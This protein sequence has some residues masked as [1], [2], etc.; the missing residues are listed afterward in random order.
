VVTGLPRVILRLEGATVFVASVVLYKRAHGS[1]LVFAL[2]W[3][4]P[5]ISAAGYLLG[6]RIG[7]AA[8]DA[9]HFYG[10]PIALAVAGAV[11]DRTLLYKLALIWLSHIGADRA[12]GFGLKYAS[13]FNDTHLG[14]MRRPG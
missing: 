4:V 13:A 1:W 8:Y 6:K 12:L 3:L 10:F 14:T 5:D 2:L 11:G 9:A 7:A